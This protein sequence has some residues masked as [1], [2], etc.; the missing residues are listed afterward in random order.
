MAGEGKE[1]VFLLISNNAM[2]H[3]LFCPW[4]ALLVCVT[5]RLR[6]QQLKYVQLFNVGLIDVDHVMK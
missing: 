4:I 5:W 3:L 6:Y 2:P 1:G